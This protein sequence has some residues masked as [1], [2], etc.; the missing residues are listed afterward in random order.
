[1]WNRRI[2]RYCTHSVA[3]WT[4]GGSLKQLF[5][6]L[7]PPEFVLADNSYGCT[8]HIP[9]IL[10]AIP[11]QGNFPWYVLAT[12][13]WMGDWRSLVYCGSFMGSAFEQLSILFSL[14]FHCHSLAKSDFTKVASASPNISY[15]EPL[16]L[17]A[18]ILIFRK[19]MRFNFTRNISRPFYQIP[20]WWRSPHLALFPSVTLWLG[21]E[22]VMC[23]KLRCMFF[24]LC[25]IKRLQNWPLA[26]QKRRTADATATV[27]HITNC[28]FVSPNGAAQYNYQPTAL[29]SCVFDSALHWPDNRNCFVVVAETVEFSSS[30]S[31]SAMRAR[32]TKK[33][34]SYASEYHCHHPYYQQTNHHHARH[35]HAICSLSSARPHHPR[36]NGSSFPP[37]TEVRTN[38]AHTD[39]TVQQQ[40]ACHLPSYVGQYY[41]NWALYIACTSHTYLFIHKP[42]DFKAC[43]QT[44]YVYKK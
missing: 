3:I 14:F 10:P 41:V 31:R 43:S 24:F 27:H 6:K 4:V 5:R 25:G 7:G 30:C 1:M 17:H 33:K 29:D 28:L 32:R 34:F 37:V 2:Y 42:G 40:A 16:W 9:T 22:V 15:I 21:R 13:Q 39:T 44:L 18:R 35:Q 38:T 20:L 26:D 8:K 12:R 23:K 36:E 19:S 11:Y